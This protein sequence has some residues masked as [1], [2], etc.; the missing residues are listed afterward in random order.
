MKPTDSASGAFDSPEK[1]GLPALDWVRRVGAE[2]E[3]VE[4]IRRQ[5]RRRRA[6]WLAA[7]AG[8]VVLLLF[9]TVTW[10]GDP[11]VPGTVTTAVSGP[12]WRSLP[13]GSSVELK[14]GADLAYEEQGAVR[15]VVLRR[16]EAHFQ[17]RKDGRAFVVEAAGVQIRAVGTA[18]AVGLGTEKVEVVVTEGRVQVVPERA[19][20]DAENG[21]AAGPEL[22]AGHRAFVAHGEGAVRV[23]TLDSAGLAARLAWRVPNLEFSRTPLGEVVELMNRHGTDRTGIFFAVGDPELHDVAL[24]GFLRADNVEGLVRLLETQFGLHAERSEDTITLRRA[25]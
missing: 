2:D 13:D 12:E 23:E 9:A 25:P 16:G 7:A 19:T 22:R 3:L 11:A 1:A 8:C 5:V 15:R 4:E 10:Q 20:A 14:P 6:R 24:S 21:T 17:V 18:F